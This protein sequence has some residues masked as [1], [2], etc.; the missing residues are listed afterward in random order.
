MTILGAH[1]HVHGHSHDGHDH[2]H[3]HA[4]HSHGNQEPLL[5]GGEKKKANINLEGA[6]LHVLGDLLNSVGVIIAAVIIWFWPEAKI[7]DPLVTFIF[8]IIIIGT[9]YP[10]V[11]KCLLTL[12]EATP[13]DIDYF[14]V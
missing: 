4:G 9:S 6:T 14:K 8:T 1:D 7:A 2:G 3:S 13:A 11:K 12:M 10:T 5:E